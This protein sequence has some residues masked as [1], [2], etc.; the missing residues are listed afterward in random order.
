MWPKH[1]IDYPRDQ[2]LRTHLAAA[3]VRFRQMPVASHREWEARWRTVFQHAFEPGARFRHGARAVDE[4]LRGPAGE[5]VVVPFLSGVPGTSVHVHRLQMNAF[6]CDGPLQALDE[7]LNV[8]FFVSPPDLAW[9]FVRTHEDFVYD[10]PY[11]AR[12]AGRP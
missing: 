12:A 2:A 1:E 9:T 6:E 11:F 3:G 10:G 7:F 4:F 8:E 5:W